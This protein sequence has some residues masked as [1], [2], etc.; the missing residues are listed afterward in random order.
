VR[1]IAPERPGFGL[2]TFDET[3][4]VSDWPSSIR[5]LA[6]HLGIDRFAVLGGS[7]GAPYALACAHALPADMI[8]AV[9][10]LAPAA[11]WIEGDL[12]GVPYSVSGWL[13]IL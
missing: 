2:S 4:R 1:V 8:S 9:G 10:L 3:H 11:P 7:G 5:A 6:A 12:A 13:L